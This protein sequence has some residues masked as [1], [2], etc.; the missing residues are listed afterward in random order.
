MIRQ[1][2]CVGLILAV[3]V[4]LLMVVGLDALAH[5]V[6]SRTIDRRM[7]VDRVH[8]LAGQMEE[9]RIQLEKDH[10]Q[11]QQDETTNQDI[12]NYEAELQIALTLPDDYQDNYH[13]QYP[14]VEDDQNWDH[15]ESQNHYQ[16]LL[17]K[18]QQEEQQHQQ[19]QQKEKSSYN[20]NDDGNEYHLRKIDSD[21]ILIDLSDYGPQDYE[22]VQYDE[23]NQIINAQ[24]Q[25]DKILNIQRQ[26]QE[27][28]EKAQHQQQQKEKLKSKKQIVDDVKDNPT[29]APTEKP[30][31]APTVKP[32][33]APTE[34]PTP[35][36]TEAPTVKPTEK[37]T[38]KPTEKPTEAPTVPPTE[39]PTEAPT[40]PPT[41][42]PTEPPTEKPTDKPTEK[43]TEAPTVPPTEKP[44]EAPTPKPTE[45]PTVKPT[46]KPTE[47]PTVK[48]TPKPTEAPTVPPTEAPTVKPTPKPTEAPTVKPTEKPTDK[49]T[50]KPTEAP[51]VPPTVKPT[52]AP[53]PKPTEAPTVPP[54][55]KPTEAPTVPPTE[56]PTVPPTEAPTVPPTP[57]PTEAP[58]VPPTPK[59]TEAPTVPP[60]PKPTERPTTPSHQPPDQ[61]FSC[62]IE[63]KQSI[64]KNLTYPLALKSLEVI[65][66]EPYSHHLLIVM[67]KIVTGTIFQSNIRVESV[68]TSIIPQPLGLIYHLFGPVTNVNGLTMMR[69]I[70]ATSSA[71]NP[72]YTI[73][74]I[75]L[76][77]R[78][79][80]FYTFTYF[81]PEEVQVKFTEPEGCSYLLPKPTTLPQQPPPPQP[82][83]DGDAD[84]DDD[85][86][87]NHINN[88][89]RD[90][91]CKVSVQQQLIDRK[92]GIRGQSISTFSVLMT[93]V[94]PRAK[95][96]DVVMRPVGSVN[97]ASGV[98]FWAAASIFHFAS[99]KVVHWPAQIRSI[100][101]DPGSSFVWYYNQ[102]NSNHPAN[103]E[104]LQTVCIPEYN[105]ISTEDKRRK[106]RVSLKQ[107]LDQLGQLELFE[108]KLLNNQ[109][110]HNIN[111]NQNNQNNNHN[112]KN[113]KK[114]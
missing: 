53:T 37:P 85:D 69:S 23:N 105:N 22:Y 2:T 18:R 82:D 20:W 39:K 95:L 16:L 62:G 5:N 31:E 13:D 114:D 32:T 15:Y 17:Q 71:T 33:D 55:V 96:Y 48:P 43:P 40:E 81:A 26:Q 30:T 111:N 52:E 28:K 97:E 83:N 45:A 25:L 74:P 21:Q 27:E 86:N 67:R 99:N 90:K 42:K 112:H 38:D 94:S 54:T 113:I 11:Q 100:G 4:V 12:G 104:I 89:P 10:R 87:S 58:T 65:N 34:A 36:P 78:P 106:K 49:P 47:A 19:Q 79:S 108:E 66:H 57:K 56:A 44:T 51:T 41:E 8:A 9:E 50:E 93:N 60:T 64:V 29:D 107:Q 61:T 68:W 92:Q 14:D 70:D 102:I 76:P 72:K 88:N 73:P 101:I 84:D 77:I 7:F 109:K 75:S 1:V 46:P 110:H 59:P 35:K 3:V 91:S 80:S 6:D 98:E 24:S 103:I 63:I